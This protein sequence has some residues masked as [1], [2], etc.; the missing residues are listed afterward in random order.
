MRKLGLAWT[1]WRVDRVDLHYN[2][3][4]RLNEGFFCSCKADYRLRRFDTDPAV[5]VVGLFGPFEILDRGSLGPMLLR[6]RHND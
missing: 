6:S 5:M 1:I 3:G 4:A 2:L